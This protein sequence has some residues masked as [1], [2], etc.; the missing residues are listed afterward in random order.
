MAQGIPGQVFS[1]SKFG[2]EPYSEMLG[3]LVVGRIAD[4]VSA[5]KGPIYSAS[6]V[7]V[8]QTT[9]SVTNQVVT[10][11]ATGQARNSFVY[12]PVTTGP[13]QGAGAPPFT[14]VGAAL[15]WN[16]TTR[17]LEVWSSGALDWIAVSS[18]GAFSS[19]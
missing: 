11:S 8:V 19:S 1:T 4:N 5:S 18:S 6:G 7:M 12:I 14:G 10:T 9:A 13:M 16:D 3:P 17:R 2:G 15:V